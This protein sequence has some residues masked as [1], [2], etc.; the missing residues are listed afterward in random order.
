[1]KIYDIY[2]KEIVS[3]GMN[4]DWVSD[5]I[6][7]MEPKIE[8]F[9]K[10]IIRMWG[11]RNYEKYFWY[12]LLFSTILMSLRFSSFMNYDIIEGN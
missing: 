7:V 8:Q 3:N 5:S 12:V 1:M 2:F 4:F 10:N 9:L 6:I 11:V